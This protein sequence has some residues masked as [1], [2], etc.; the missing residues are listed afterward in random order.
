MCG[1]GIDWGGE[2]I[3]EDQHVC[4]VEVFKEC[5]TGWVVVFEHGEVVG[6]C[7]GA[8]EACGVVVSTR[9]CE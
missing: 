3:I 4:V 9:C 7:V 8:E 5:D 2:E 6:K 1:D